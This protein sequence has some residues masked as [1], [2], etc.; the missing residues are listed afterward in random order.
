MND[1]GT[2]SPPPPPPRRLVF[3]PQPRST[4]AI[5]T[6]AATRTAPSRPRTAMESTFT[7]TTTTTTT[8]TMAEEDVADA[9]ATYCL[10]VI[11]MLHGWAQNVDVFSNR[12]KKFIKR[13]TQAGYSVVFVQAPHRLPP[14][15]EELTTACTQPTAPP[16][17]PHSR[18]Y[19]YAW[20]LYDDVDDDDDDDNDND[21]SN[22]SHTR[23]TTKPTVLPSPTGTYRGMEHS[24]W[25][26]H[27]ELTC[28]RRNE[29]GRYYPTRKK[30]K[31]IHNDD[32]NIW[33]KK[34]S[35]SDK[36]ND[37]ILDDHPCSVPSPSPSPPVYIL[38]FSQGA[39]LV[40]KIATLVCYN[41]NDDDDDMDD[42]HDDNHNTNT[43]NDTDNDNDND[44]DNDD[45]RYRHRY[46]YRYRYRYKYWYCDYHHGHH[47]YHHHHHYR[48]N[49]PRLL[50]YEQEQHPVKIQEYKRVAMAMAMERNKDDHRELCR[51]SC[52]CHYV[53]CSKY[54][55]HR[56]G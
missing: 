46:R 6:T 26:I 2:S 47:P 8:T 51:W 43:Y 3:R 37:I 24:L 27:E 34:H 39:V 56:C 49:T 18:E 36:T 33:N 17:I 19:A 23:A 44:D 29:E 50:S 48:C 16:V 42:G 15:A 12:T 13:L 35:D 5:T 25:I 1:P 53:S 11:V 9:D 45:H 32:K 40:H 4:P 22:S 30:K 55:C 28:I 31:I 52:R 54:F 7:A 38:G 21:E 10:G 41:D 20:F 14:L